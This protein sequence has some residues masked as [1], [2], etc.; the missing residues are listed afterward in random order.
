VVKLR[1]ES[2]NKSRKGLYERVGHMTVELP[3]V[4]ILRLSIFVF[5][6]KKKKKERPNSL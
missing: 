4:Y 6:G 2:L 5:N 3:P 1:E